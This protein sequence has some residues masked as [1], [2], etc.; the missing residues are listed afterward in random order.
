LHFIF[1]HFFMNF[2]DFFSHFFIM[3]SILHFLT[4]LR[5]LQFTLGGGGGGEGLGGGGEGE[6]GGGDGLGGGGD[7]G[8]GLS[9]L[10]SHTASAKMR[11]GSQLQSK[12]VTC[13]GIA[14]AAS[15]A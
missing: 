7:G 10:G 12:G 13:V 4:S 3:I 15:L 2:D 8:L 6:G 11:E 9:R 5:P 1:L 14:E